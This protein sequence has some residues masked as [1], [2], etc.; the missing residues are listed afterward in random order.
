MRVRAA[1]AAVLVVRHARDHGTPS[2]LLRAAY[3][4]GNR[5]VAVELKPD[6]LKFEPDHVLGEML[7]RLHLD[8]ERRAGTVRA[9]GRCLRAQ[10]A[11]HTMKA[12]RP[13]PRTHRRQCR[14]RQAAARRTASATCT[15]RAAA[16]P[17]PRPRMSASAPLLRLMW[18][19]SPALPVGGFSYS[20]GPGSGRRGRSRRD[21]AQAGDW[22][23]DQLQLSLARCDLALVAQA[24]GAWQADDAARDRR[25]QRLGRPAAKPPSCA[26][27]RCRPAAR[28]W[29]AAQRRAGDDP[30]AALAGAGAGA[31]WPVAF[32]LATVL[33]GAAPR[34]ALLAFCLWAGPRTWRRPP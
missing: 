10:A 25:A 31:Q 7:Q 14:P 23:L 16:W 26:R 27:R 32:A 17:R 33:A 15:A 19:A 9:R 3:H 24:I 18:L 13:R 1:P 4:L 29:M 22:L 11:T 21:E 30:P 2:D 8:R 6:H 5:H 20:R 28:C 12:R 34:D